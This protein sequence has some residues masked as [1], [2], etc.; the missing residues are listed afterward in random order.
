MKRSHQQQQDDSGGGE[1]ANGVAHGD[2]EVEFIDLTND[3]EDEEDDRESAPNDATKRQQLVNLHEAC[4]HSLWTFAAEN[5]EAA[6]MKVEV[7]DSDEDI[8]GETKASEQSNADVR[9][10]SDGE[11]EEHGDRGEAKPRGYG[12]EEAHQQEAK[13]VAVEE[14]AH[15]Q[16]S[17]IKIAQQ[18]KTGEERGEKKQ[19][20]RREAV[21]DGQGRE[22]TAREDEQGNRDEQEELAPEE[23]EEAMERSPPPPRCWCCRTVLDEEGK[24]RVAPCGHLHCLSC[25]AARASFGYARCCLQEFPSELVREALRSIGQVILSE[26]ERRD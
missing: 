10:E 5:G 3:D 7:C 12:D 18:M 11:E 17:A 2:E 24:R 4:R 15:E 26:E 22:R 13:G 16:Q 6:A 20:E 21:H 25:V 1:T 19:R 23:E 14:V 8:E 9:M